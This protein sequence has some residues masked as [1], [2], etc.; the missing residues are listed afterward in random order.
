MGKSKQ[1][2]EEEASGCKL[3]MLRLVVL[4]KHLASRIWKTQLG[5]TPGKIRLVHFT[6]RR[7]EGGLQLV[8]KKPSVRHPMED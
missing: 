1:Q 4:L 3:L 6:K 2:E 8:D 7:A 5:Q